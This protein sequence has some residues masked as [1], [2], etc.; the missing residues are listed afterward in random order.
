VNDLTF[1]LRAVDLLWSQGVRT[2]IC[3]GWAEELRGLSPVRQHEDL[4][5]L[6]P[7]PGWTRVDRLEL[8]WVE[9]KRFPWKRAFVLDGVLVELVLVERDAQGAWFT[10]LGRRRHIWPPDTFAANGRLPVASA[11]ALTGYRGSYRRAA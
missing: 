2:W 8:D 11:A 3:G 7:A 10:G 1:V 5:L 6:Y 4:D 9:G